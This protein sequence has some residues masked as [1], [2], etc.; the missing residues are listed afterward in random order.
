MSKKRNWF[1]FNKK[2]NQNEKNL[3]SFNQSTNWNVNPKYDFTQPDINIYAV[4]EYIP[5]GSDNLYPQT[6]LRMYQSSPFHNAI[7]EFKTITAIGDGLEIT[8]NDKLEGKVLKKK[9]EKLLNN[10]F[11]KRIIKEY[12][13]HNRLYFKVKVGKTDIELIPAEFVRASANHKNERIVNND[14]IRRRN[15]YDKIYL[16]DKY[17]EKD[18]QII[19]YMDDTPGTYIYSVPHYSSSSNWIWLD[20]EIAFFQKQNM[21]N[22]VNPSMIVKIYEDIEDPDLKEKWVSN[23]RR[24]FEGAR[25]SGKVFVNFS[26]GKEL[27]PDFIMQDPN[28]LDKAFTDTQENI[29][30][31]VSYSHLINPVLMGISTEGKLGATNEIND[32]YKLYQINYLDNLQNEIEYF[33]NDVLFKLNIDASVKIKKSDIKFETDKNNDNKYE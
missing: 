31:N 28:Q 22:S 30:K 4:G 1:G 8:T 7:I 23:F 6:L 32:A 15:E 12:I 17:N 5:F 27:S 20:G 16:F 2:E 24:S 9:L 29:I 11:L 13:I 25:N 3:Y 26:N 33:L 19:E 18:Y 14:W 21:E 10:R